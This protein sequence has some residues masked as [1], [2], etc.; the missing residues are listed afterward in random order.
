[1]LAEQEGGG[2]GGRIG[3][4][5]V[6]LRG[7]VRRRPRFTVARVGRMGVAVLHRNIVG[8]RLGRE[9]EVGEIG[10]RMRWT[11]I[12]G[13]HQVGVAPSRPRY[14][15]IFRLA[16]PGSEVIHR[17][18][19]LRLLLAASTCAR[20]KSGEGSVNVQPLRHTGGR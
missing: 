13:W 20:G 9:G 6:L 11:L 12:V 14:V 7:I 16:P 4:G 10:W 19:L 8:L 5:I 2:D 3:L 1:M 17:R 18:V 15:P